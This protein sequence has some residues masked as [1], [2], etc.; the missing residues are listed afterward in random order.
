MRDRGAFGDGA[1]VVDAGGEAGDRRFDRYGGEA[2]TGRLVRGLATGARGRAAAGAVFEVVGGRAARRVDARF[3]LRGARGEGAV[4]GFCRVFR[5]G[6][7]LGQ[8]AERGVRA[9]FGEHIDRV[10]CPARDIDGAARGAARG[11][12]GDSVGFFEARRF[13]ALDQPAV[14]FDPVAAGERRF[15]FGAEDRERGA[16]DGLDVDGVDLVEPFTGQA[17][18][19]VHGDGRRR[20]VVERRYGHAAATR[21]ELGHHRLGRVEELTVFLDE[22]TEELGEGQILFTFFFAGLREAAAQ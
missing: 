5:A 4:F 17:R 13:E 19:G 9:R 11:V 16:R 15:G 21:F 3:E 10:G 2:A 22:F 1:V 18:P 7:V 20:F 8:G 6:G 14:A 12:H